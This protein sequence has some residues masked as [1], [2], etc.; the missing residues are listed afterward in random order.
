M[1]RNSNFGIDY[2]FVCKDF[3]IRKEKKMYYKLKYFIR[4]KIFYRLHCFVNKFYYDQKLCREKRPYLR[5]L[6]DFFASLWLTTLK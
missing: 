1:V 2:I 6:N 5:F 4:M 3:W